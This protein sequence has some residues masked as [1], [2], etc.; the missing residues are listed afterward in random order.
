MANETTKK[1][2][3]KTPTAKKR[4][5]Q[6]E[7]NRILN[8]SFRSQVNTAIK[9]FNDSN[10]S[11]AKDALGTVYSMMDRGVKKGIFKQNKADRVK[12]RITKRLSTKS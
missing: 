2:K 11:S 5:K 4:D 12:S 1:A 6:S 8:K 7:K 9:A 10:A 3:V